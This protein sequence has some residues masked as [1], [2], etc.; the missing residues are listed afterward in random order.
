MNVSEILSQLSLKFNDNQSIGDANK[1][2]SRKDK[3]N[4]QH[5]E[6]VLSEEIEYLKTDHQIEFADEDYDFEEELKK[7]ES[8]HNS[9]IKYTPE[10]WQEIL[11]KKFVLRWNFNTIQHDHKLLRNE[12]EIYNYRVYLE[13]GETK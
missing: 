2:L 12:K 4:L 9:K 13:E 5:L 10:K 6:N 11:E 8:T 1:E 3:K 7:L